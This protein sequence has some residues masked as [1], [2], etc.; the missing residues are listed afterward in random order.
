MSRNFYQNLPTVKDP[1][2]ELLSEERHFTEVPSTWHIVIT[3]IE[4]STKAVSHGQHQLV[5]LIATGSII[6]ALN[7][8]YRS[9]TEIPFFFGGDG[10][11]ILLPAS[12]LDQCMGA[13]K[14][15]QRNVQNN[16]GL[17]LRVGSLPVQEVYE[18]KEGIRI[19]KL[20]LNT[21]LSAP[22][23]LGNGLQFAEAVIKANEDHDIDDTSP[24]ELDL[25]GM[26]C[27][28]DHIKPPQDPGE[29]L[30]LL[31]DATNI[32]QQGQV[33]SK[34]MRLIEKSYGPLNQRNPVSV[35]QLRLKATIA[36]I[37]AETRVKFG[38]VAT[39]QLLKNWLFTNIASLYFGR[40]KRSHQYMQNLVSLSETLTIDGR[41]NTVISGTGAQREHLIK[42]LNEMESSGVIIFGWHVSSESV[43]SCYV[44]NRVDEHI[45]FIDGA[46][47]G[48]TKAAR[49]LKEKKMEVS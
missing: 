22:I 31:V 21:F 48:Y 37:G 16:F 35:K 5:N 13:L 6:A 30:S 42:S 41:I 40:E 4:D 24:D 26:E 9:K 33:F 46:G 2:Y 45:H 36:Q 11:S 17:N 49:M 15:H 12:I 3:D 20:A 44:R 34:V 28:W 1:V 7:L 32:A 23:V 10:A 39:L 29:V 19:A 14:S 43:I 47:G 8:A 38:R 25:T 27:R 18:Q